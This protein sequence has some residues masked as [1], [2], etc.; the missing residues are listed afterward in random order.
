MSEPNGRFAQE[1]IAALHKKGLTENEL[2][3]KM[4]ISY[5]FVRQM[6]I[7]KKLPSKPMLRELCRVLGLNYEAMKDLVV[8]DQLANKYGDAG[9]RAIGKSPRVGQL[10]SAGLNRLN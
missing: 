10:E 8:E 2:A 5:E 6:K 4:E 1:L 3:A 7:G 9:M